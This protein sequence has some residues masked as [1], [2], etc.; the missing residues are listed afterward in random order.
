MCKLCCK[1]TD[2][3]IHRKCNANN[4]NKIIW[5]LYQTYKTVIFVEDNLI[6]FILSTG[7]EEL[8]SSTVCI[9]FTAV[10]AKHISHRSG[11]KDKLEWQ[12]I[13]LAKRKASQKSLFE[14]VEE[15]TT[16][17]NPIQYIHVEFYT[18]FFFGKRMKLQPYV[19]LNTNGKLKILGQC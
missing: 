7:Q 11:L 14:H 13:Y 1:Y 9:T 19:L 3:Y 18:S 16:D 2:L 5:Q 4:F 8:W 17:T 15:N 6:C 12:F 10:A